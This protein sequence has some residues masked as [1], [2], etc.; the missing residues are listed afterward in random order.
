[1]RCGLLCLQAGAQHRGLMF[2][3]LGDEGLLR[4]FCDLF[5]GF[6][7]VDVSVPSKADFKPSLWS[8]V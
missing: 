1:V 8:R 2:T 3:L 4:D 6:W 5:I 7:T